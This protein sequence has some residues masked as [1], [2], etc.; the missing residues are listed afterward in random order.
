MTIL[1]SNKDCAFSAQ[2]VLQPYIDKEHIHSLVNSAT[3][4]T[5]LFE[6]FM[7][8]DLFVAFFISTPEVLNLFLFFTTRTGKIHRFQI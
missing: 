5:E 4:S 7:L 8:S 2:V 3:L 1:P 6:D